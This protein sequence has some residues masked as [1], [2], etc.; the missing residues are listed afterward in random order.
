MYNFRITSNSSSSSKEEMCTEADAWWRKLWK[1]HYEEQFSS[2]YKIFAEDFK[3][4]NQD[5]GNEENLHVIKNDGEST[6][7]SQQN[8]PKSIDKKK[9]KKTVQNSHMYLNSVS[10][11][12]KRLESTYLAYEKEE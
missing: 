1:E 2:C 3:R 12:L 6:G 9:K 11:V 8:L 10:H 7:D 4:K 5:T